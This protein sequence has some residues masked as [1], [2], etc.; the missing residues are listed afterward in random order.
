MALDAD[1]LAELKKLTKVLS[2]RAG[3][4]G[5]DAEG[6]SFPGD[7]DSARAQEYKKAIKE[8]NDIYKDLFSTDSNRL[9]NQKKYVA[10]LEKEFEEA[11]KKK[12]VTAEE[13]AS[14]REKVIQA[15]KFSE[16]V[17]KADEAAEGLADSFSNIFG[18]A[19]AFKLEDALNPKNFIE[20]GKSML[21]VADAADR[22]EAMD[23]IA[24]KAATAFT[25]SIVKQT[26]AVAD[27]KVEFMKTTGASAEFAASLTTQYEEAREFGATT[28][29]VIA[30]NQA[31]YTT[32][33]DFTLI[34]ESARK[35]IALQ[36]TE[37]AK[38]GVSNEDFAS[39][40]QL[41]TKALGMSVEQAGDN[42]ED[43]A[44]F[45]SDLGVAPSELA[46]QFAGAGDMLAKLGSEGTKAFK[47][48]A[49]AA[50][51]TGMSIE[52]IVNLT[53]QF[54][55]FEGAAGMA[56]KLNAALGGNFVN[57][58]DLM[59]ATEPAERF[60]MIRDSIL[61][62]GLSFD[63]MSYYQKNFFKDSLGLKDVGELAALM[64][65]DMD[66]VSGAV[67]QSSDQLLD[68]KKR[69][70][71]LASMQDRLN[72]VL[73]SAIPIIEPLI[74]FLEG[75][76]KTLTDNIET[77]KTV[78]KVLGYLTL[79]YKAV[80]SAMM[81]QM[82]LAKR[83][84]L[85]Q[86]TSIAQTV[87]QTTVETTK[88]TV[89]AAGNTIKS[90]TVTITEAQNRANQRGGRIAGAAAKNMLAFGAAILM[91]GAGVGLAA[92]GVAELVKSFDG[93]GKM[94]PY[95]V[96]GIV[97]FTVAFGILMALLIGLVAGPQA[98]LTA[99][100]VGV[101]LAVGGAVLMMGGAVAAAAIGFS[102]LIESIGK[103]GEVSASLL[104]LPVVLYGIAA[105][106]AVFANP[107]T[108]SGIAMA[109]PLFLAMGAAAAMMGNDTA[110]AFAKVTEAITAIPTKKNLEF[111]TSM[112]TAAAAMTT[113][114]VAGVVFG[115]NNQAA[116]PSV[117]Q[118][119]N[120]KPYVVNINLELDGK[121][122]DQRTVKLMS[123][124][125]VEAA[126]GR[127]GAV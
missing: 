110:E 54:D 119:A 26:F 106:M 68:A 33:T 107:L 98:A 57:A 105:S 40:I 18:G 104:M 122:L 44:K 42:M 46:R 90:T 24:T 83:R 47:D 69:A 118:N 60:G 127:G 92:L 22:M 109:I 17:E 120:Q 102:Y 85:L 50:K 63:E 25:D 108:L 94:A 117:A 66:L 95:A 41:S 9:K 37:L 19:D 10:E 91:V 30:S 67:N 4:A 79:G 34:S 52:S 101:I 126:G 39:A 35:S 58:M 53:N 112:K 116:A 11:K 12:E 113:A 121:Q 100:G 8:I 115:A 70:Q 13:I 32:F 103:L 71:E 14:L 55:T 56:G 89:D 20:V 16:E 80:R 29:D 97:A 36:G 123:G 114:A 3:A 84:L 73:Q 86:G 15:K 78:I 5:A 82:F 43:L 45:A 6:L 51:V 81:L 64:S 125:A 72:M 88:N 124:K 77:T 93:L 65:G 48:L 76:T 49:I 61:D 1:I 38:L 62:T 59:M 87:T 111:Q 21:L 27:M 74:K 99:A 28:Q 23:Q 75:F 2:G 31:L 96:G 7:D